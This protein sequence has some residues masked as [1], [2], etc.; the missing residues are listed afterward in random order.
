MEK[1]IYDKKKILCDTAYVHTRMWQVLCF[2]LKWS[3]VVRLYPGWRREGNENGK[4]GLKRRHELWERMWCKTNIIF[5]SKVCTHLIGD[6]CFQEVSLQLIKTVI[7]SV[8]ISIAIRNS[9]RNIIAYY[10]CNCK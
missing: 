8:I 9:M 10:A 5:R 1:R 4:R 7:R 2:S 6:V 3:D